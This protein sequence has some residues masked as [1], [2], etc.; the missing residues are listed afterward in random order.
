VGAGA[1]EGLG[2]ARHDDVPER[3]RGGAHPKA[4]S[5]EE[6]REGAAVRL[7]DPVATHSGAPG[8]AGERGKR[9]A[10]QAER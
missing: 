2:I 3:H 4:E 8:A 7:D 10:D 9:E 1:V 5:R 6:V